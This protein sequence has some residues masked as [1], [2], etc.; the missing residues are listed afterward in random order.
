MG[1]TRL[2]QLCKQAENKVDTKPLDLQHNIAQIESEWLAVDAAI[3][4]ASTET[5]ENVS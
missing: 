2:F 3:Q 5:K 4:Q 1:A